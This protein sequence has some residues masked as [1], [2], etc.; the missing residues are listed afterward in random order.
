MGTPMLR[1]QRVWLHM[2][3]KADVLST[4]IDDR[5][6]GHYAGF[7]F[8][9][10]GEM[11]E[12]W[13]SEL[14]GEMMAGTAYQFTI[15]PLGSREPIGAA[16]LRGIDQANG[17]AW[18]SIFL[19]DAT[20]WGT[21]LGTDAM[22]ALLDFGFGELRLERIGLDVFDYNERAIASYRKAG[23]VE[24]VRRRRARFHRGA[25]HDVVTMAILRAEWE[26]L[27]RPRSWDLPDIAEG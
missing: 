14:R 8:A 4:D 23:Y 18:V 27:D 26:A 22:H 17:S 16:G 24:E 13:L 10:S 25:F 5:D 15:C 2:I 7:K 1:G 20:R 6:L 12:G 11:A 9:F 21:G 19:T 3:E